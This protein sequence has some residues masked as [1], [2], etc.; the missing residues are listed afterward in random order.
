MG[1][2][3]LCHILLELSCKTQKAPYQIYVPS[4]RGR[5]QSL[6][7]HE[8][9]SQSSALNVGFMRGQ[10]LSLPHRCHL[11]RGP[12]TNLMRNRLSSH[13]RCGRHVQCTSPRP[14]WANNGHCVTCSIT[15]SVRSRRLNWNKNSGNL[16]PLA[17]VNQRTPRKGTLALYQ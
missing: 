9:F 15:A 5:T 2:F 11:C 14:V 3:S 1:Y 4:G 6:R 17:N 7:S 12:I 13:H 10:P 8:Q 16:A